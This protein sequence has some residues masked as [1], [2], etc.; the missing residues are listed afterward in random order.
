[1]QQDLPL[2]VSTL[3]HRAD[4]ADSQLISFSKRLGIAEA[5]EPRLSSLEPRVLRL[6]KLA[7]GVALATIFGVAAGN[8]AVKL[9]QVILAYFGI[10]PL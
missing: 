4:H 3:E 6:E 5:L 8:G 2:R 9:I 1:M 7:S 10:S